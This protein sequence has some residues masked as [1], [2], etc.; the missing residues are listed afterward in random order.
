MFKELFS[1]PI[2]NN[3]IGFIGG[4]DQKLTILGELHSSDL[5]GCRLSKALVDSFGGVNCKGS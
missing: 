4:D 1:L 5:I 3:A 2:I